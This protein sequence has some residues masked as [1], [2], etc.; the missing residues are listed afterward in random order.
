MRARF[1]AAT[2]VEEDDTVFSWIEEFGVILGAFS[3]WTSVEKY[4]SVGMS[5]SFS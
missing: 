4:D 2:L 3:P 1:A 5:Y